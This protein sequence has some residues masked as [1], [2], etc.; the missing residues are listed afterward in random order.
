MDTGDFF[1]IKPTS[2]VFIAVFLSAPKNEPMLVGLI[3]AVLIDSGWERVVSATVLNPFNITEF[4]ADKR[5]I[6]DV[7]VRDESDRLFNIEIQTNPHPA[8]QERILYGW[9][10]SYSSQIH[11][12]EKYVELQPVFAVVITEFPIFSKVAGV[13]L[14]FEARERA[15]PALVL[16]KHF[17]V[18]FLR[19]HEYMKENQDELQGL[20]PELDHWLKFLVFGGTISEEEMAQ[21]TDNDPLVLEAQKEFHRFTSNTQMQEFERRRKLFMIDYH[22]GMSSSRKE[23]FAEGKTE[24]LT[25]GKAEG[26]T[27]GKV[28]GEIL[29]MLRILKARFGSVPMELQNRLFVITDLSQLESLGIKAATCQ[30]LDEFTLSLH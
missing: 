12:G 28:E 23:G 15:S 9:A 16:S 26:K 27:E 13:H 21:I 14:V 25:E 20:A 6:L 3:N 4:A 11:S 7:R 30:S 2:D 1:T 22:L 18:H 24:G 19:L 5:I 29:M 8:F 10:N 17:Q